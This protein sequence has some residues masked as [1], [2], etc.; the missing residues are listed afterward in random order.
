MQTTVIMDKYDVKGYSYDY[1]GNSRFPILNYGIDPTDP[2]GWE[3]AEIRLRP[4]YVDNDFDTG[5]IDFNW[6]ISPG[7]RLKGGV[8]ARTTRS[9]PPNCAVPANWPCRPSP[10]AAGSCPW[11]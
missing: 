6:N 7:F 8:L 3:L 1:R 4:Q 9:R 2:N 11:T 10:A 5:Q